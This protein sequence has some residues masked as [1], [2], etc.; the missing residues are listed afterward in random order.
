MS[1]CYLVQHLVHLSWQSFCISGST[2][3]PS[4]VISAACSIRYASCHKTLL[5]YILKEMQRDRIPDVYECQVLPS[6]LLAVRV[7]PRLLYRSTFKITASLQRTHI[8]VEKSFY[9]GNCLQSFASHDTA[10]NLVD[11]LC[12]LLASGG[13]E[14]RQWS[15]NDPSV[16]NHLPAE[17]QSQSNILWLSEGHQ[18][19]QEST[20][21][22]Q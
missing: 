11:K 3:L 5:R 18:E 2:Q 20:L 13:F 7:V 4:V 19:A 14:L 17:I 10:K 22:L 6:E 8:S 15:S 16:I 21:G 12:S 9:V 1:S